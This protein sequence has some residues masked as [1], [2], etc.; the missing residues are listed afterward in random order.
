MRASPT[1]SGRTGTANDFCITKLLKRIPRKIEFAKL[2]PQPCK[3]VPQY[4]HSLR[5]LSKPQVFAQIL[6]SIVYELCSRENITQKL[7]II[8]S[9]HNSQTKLS[10]NWKW[11]QN[12][13][14]S[15]CSQA[16]CEIIQ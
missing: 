7:C 5:V 3:Y 12:Q 6:C 9:F 10:T 2:N 1:L 13:Q 8:K 14:P 11:R 15:S 16:N 4:S